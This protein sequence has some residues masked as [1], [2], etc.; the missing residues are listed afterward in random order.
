MFSLVAFAVATAAAAAIVVAI[1]ALAVYPIYDS[2]VADV[3]LFV[4]SCCFF[5]LS[6]TSERELCIELVVLIFFLL[7]LHHAKSTLFTLALQFSVF[8]N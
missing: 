8:I 3:R 4:R 1:V 7:P 5:F 2:Q 6:L